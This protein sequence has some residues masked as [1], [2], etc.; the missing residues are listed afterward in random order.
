MAARDSDVL[1]SIRA[2]LTDLEAE[3]SALTER[4]EQLPAR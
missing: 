4:L 2:R 3:R 1:D